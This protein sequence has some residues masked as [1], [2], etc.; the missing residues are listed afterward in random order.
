MRT[1]LERFCEIVCPLNIFHTTD[2]DVLWMVDPS[3]SPFLS[4]SSS[5]QSLY[6]QVLY[7]KVMSHP[8]HM[9]LNI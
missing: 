7:V 4:S 5:Y 9:P 6:A 2:M 8:S 3:T 1:P